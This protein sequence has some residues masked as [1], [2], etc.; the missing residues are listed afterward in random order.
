MNF[1]FSQTES[2]STE[3]KY[4]ITTYNKNKCEQIQK[5]MSTI[6]IFCL[7]QN[8]LLYFVKVRRG[9]RKNGCY[10]KVYDIGKKIEY[11]PWW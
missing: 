5:F 7:V 2:V 1:R 11:M 6:N 3:A 8:T 4:K 9:A 10:D